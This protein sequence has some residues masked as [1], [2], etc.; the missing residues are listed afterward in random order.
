MVSILVLISFGRPQ[1]GY[2][3]KTNF[4]MFQIIDQE[5]CSILIFHKKGVGLASPPHFVYIFQEKYF[6]CDTMLTV[7]VSSS[8]CLY[9][10]RY[11]AILVLFSLWHGKS[12]KW[13]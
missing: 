2:T 4:I 8:G 6:P 11:W 9:I 12:C 10:L 1:F 13:P 7:L 3:V 5:I